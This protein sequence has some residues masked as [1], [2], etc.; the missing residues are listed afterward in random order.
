MS[1]FIESINVSSSGASLLS[2]HQR[3]V[4]TTFQF[5]GKFCTLDIAK[6]ASSQK[7]VDSGVHKL[8]IVYDL[9]GGFESTL[10]PYTP[11]SIPSFQL[12]ECPQIS[13]RLKK[14]DR[15]ELELTLQEIH[16]SQALI[17]QNGL[18]TDSAFSNLVFLK[19]DSWYTPES[20]LLNGV[21]RQYLLDEKRIQEV[22]IGINDLASYTHFA[23][24]NAL[25]PL[26]DARRYSLDLILNLPR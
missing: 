24:I 1:R 5:Y 12:V 17:T 9:E 20:F 8:R 23:L 4:E 7:R 19:K 14:E 3:R 21:Q 6:I 18:L 26:E 10:I 16:P 11:L 2:Y 15:R 13:Y 25:N 22:Q